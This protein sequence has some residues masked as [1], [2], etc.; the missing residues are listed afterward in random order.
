MRHNWIWP[1]KYFENITL[2]SVKTNKDGNSWV[3]SMGEEGFSWGY[4][5]SLSEEARSHI[6]WHCS[7]NVLGASGDIFTGVAF[8]DGKKGILFHINNTLH[9]AELRV[10]RVNKETIR[11]DLFD[12]PGVGY[13]YAIVLEYNAVTSM[14][15]GGIKPVSQKNKASKTKKIFEFRLPHGD[16]PAIEII[17]ALEIVT[18]QALGSNGGEAKYGGLALDCE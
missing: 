4:C 10:L 5:F 8:H 13:P 15:I 12:I 2:P 18:S 7:V 17:S 1:A 6:L 16:I 3:V 14:C 9:T 11:N